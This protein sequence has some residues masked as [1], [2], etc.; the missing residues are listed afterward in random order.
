MGY[1]PEKSQ[2][3]LWA[4]DDL[5]KAF[6][7]DDLMDKAAEKAIGLNPDVQEEYRHI[8]EEK[9]REQFDERV[10]QLGEKFKLG[11]L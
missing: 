3:F 4:W 11:K 7:D 6:R 5:I 10:G 8:L 9:E 2:R 1:N